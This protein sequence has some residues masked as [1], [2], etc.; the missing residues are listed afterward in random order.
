MFES[1]PKTPGMTPFCRLFPVTSLWRFP[2]FLQPATVFHMNTVRR[3]TGNLNPENQR[4]G[5][6]IHQFRE[7]LGYTQQELSD[8]AGISRPHLA[9]I[10]AGRKPLSNIHLAKIARALGLKPIAIKCFDS[11]DMAL[12]A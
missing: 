5:E 3:A 12:A 4:V 8:A 10:E 2:M 1:A 9:N 7:R 6:T 11:E